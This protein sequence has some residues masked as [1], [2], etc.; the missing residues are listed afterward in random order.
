[1]RERR[2]QRVRAGTFSGVEVE[3][4][5]TA[6]RSR[7]LMAE[8]RRSRAPSRLTGRNTEAAET[9]NTT[10]VATEA[11]ARKRAVET[12]AGDEPW[13]VDPTPGRQGLVTRLTR[14]RSRRL[15]PK[16]AMPPRTGSGPGT[17]RVALA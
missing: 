15:Q 14:R 16:A 1:M 3:G 17:T 2:R 9:M 12:P 11:G 4:L 7:C 13:I 8:V 6:A 5:A 10:A